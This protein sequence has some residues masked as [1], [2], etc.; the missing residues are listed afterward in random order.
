MAIVG[1]LPVTALADI[2]LYGKANVS[3][4]S[5]DEGESSVIAL[6]SNA[7]RLGFK[8]S[9]TIS[10]G[11]NVIYQME[12]ET[13]F[14]D[15][16]GNPFRQRN[17]F[18][19]LKGGFG[20]VVGGHFDTPLKNAQNK[21]DLFNDLRG[22]IK[23][24]I[25]PNDNRENNSVMYT[26]P[27]LGG[28]AAH[29]AYIASEDEEVDD[30]KSVALAYTASGFYL[31]LAFDQDVEA[32]NAE[33]LRAVLQYSISQFQLGALYEEYE[34]D[35]L[36]KEDAWIVSALYNIN[37]SWAIKGQY[38]ESSIGFGYANDLVTDD[39]ESISVGID[40]KI[41]KNLLAYGFY[42][43]ISA[44]D[45]GVEVVENDYLGVGVELRF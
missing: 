22:D 18:V 10:E 32:E 15:N 20:Q 25:T 28:L 2:T 39:N 33:T 43:T 21:V 6:E 37:D 38:G 12:Y 11:L 1:V 13:N 4:E 26:S 35:E 14:D 34:E 3:L 30:G 41:S 45:D 5:V 31:A 7:S 8:G 9:E 24:Y 40:Y 42:T 19:G 27:S 17:I 16:G 29:L 36:D 44:E 23:N